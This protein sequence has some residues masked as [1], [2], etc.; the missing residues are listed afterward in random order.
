MA[1]NTQTP[2]ATA[3][4]AP[5]PVK[6]SVAMRALKR[7]QGMPP[8]SDAPATPAPAQPPVAAKPE[9]KPAPV[10]QEAVIPPVQETIKEPA[11]QEGAEEYE[12]NPQKPVETIL[13]E[14]EIDAI[15]DP[16]PENFM[17]LRKNL[18]TTIKLKKTL[19]TELEET[20][21]RLI[22]YETGIAAPEQ[23]TKMQQRIQELEV[24]EQVHN[25]KGSPAYKENFIKPI[26]EQRTKFLELSE[27]YNLPE[28]FLD[29][30]ASI[31]NKAELNRFLSTH[32]DQ[33]AALEVKSIVENIKKVRTKA[34][35]AEKNPQVTMAH[36]EQQQKRLEEARE[37]QRAES[38]KNSSKNGWI[39]SLMQLRETGEFPELKFIEG[40]SEHNEKIARPL[41]QKA[42]S[43]YSKVVKLLSDHGIK[44]LPYEVSYALANMVQR[45]YVSSIAAAQRAHLVE[46]LETTKKLIQTRQ[47]IDRPG[48]NGVGVM[49]APSGYQQTQNPTDR[50][51]NAARRA[52]EKAS[53]RA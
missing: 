27:D 28:T 12:V 48:A 26:E 22:E 23:L 1:T 45:A 31:E 7:A 37:Q 19:E 6:E 47:N 44:Q 33:V 18:K 38:I 36:L 52:L 3:H 17:K 13:A 53:K 46:E 24:F 41:I 16:Q 15:T 39:G 40:N 51:V 25:F 34:V 50:R 49:S 10:V 20:K 14:E 5:A 42:A 43:E 11:A 35:E 32:L 29:Q 8:P 2:P 30:A 21:K 4:Q 9:A